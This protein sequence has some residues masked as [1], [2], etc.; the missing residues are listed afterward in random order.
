MRSW[1]FMR[2]AHNGGVDRATARRHAPMIEPDQ[3]DEKLAGGGSG[4]TIC[5]ASCH[6]AKVRDDFD[7]SDNMPIEFNEF[8][9]RNP[10]FLVCRR[11]DNLYRITLNERGVDL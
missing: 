5:W 7:R 2:L 1:I 3:F 4:P 9:S 11:T 8:L 10:Q 6:G